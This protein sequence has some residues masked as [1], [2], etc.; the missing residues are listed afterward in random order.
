MLATK[1][2]EEAM[3]ECYRLL[4]ANSE[5]QADFDKLV[6]NAEFNE[7][8]QK[9]ID[10]N[11]YEISEEKFSE[12]LEDII[13]KYKIKPAYRASA[14]RNSIYLGCSPKTKTTL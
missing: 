3:F 5:P 12:I 8:G 10:F 6:E 11:A 2:E 1:K 14:F 13:K 7:R 4:Y 9:V